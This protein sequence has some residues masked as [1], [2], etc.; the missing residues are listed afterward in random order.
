MFVARSVLVVA[1][2]AIA[3]GTAVAGATAAPGGGEPSPRPVDES[4]RAAHS[5][6]VAEVRERRRDPAERAQRQRSRTLFGGKSDREAIAVARAEHAG[7]MKLM[8]WKAPALRGEEHIAGWHDDYTAK[9]EGGPGEGAAL[10][11]STLPLRD[12]DREG[13][14]RLLDYSLLDV[15]SAF[16]P[17]NPLVDVRLPKQLTD[18]I[19]VGK[20]RVHPEGARNAAAVDVEDKAFWPNVD[21]DTDFVAV[22]TPVGVE[23]FHQLRSTDS[24]ET[25]RLRFDLPPGAV[26]RE[27]VERGPAGLGGTSKLFEV[28]RGDERLARI[29]PPAA[30]DADNMRVPM[31]ARVAGRTLV[32][33]VEHR[34]LDVRYPLMVDPFIDHFD[35]N[36]NWPYKNYMDNST[37]G[38]L[39][40]YFTNSGSTF[41]NWGWGL[42]GY[43]FAGTSSYNSYELGRWV[44]KA[45]GNAHI[46]RV[47]FGYV[48][49]Q[50]SGG[51]SNGAY[52][53]P[54]SYLE[55]G[56][57]ADGCGY[58]HWNWQT[59]TK[60]WYGLHYNTK[61]HCVNAQ[62]CDWGAGTSGNQAMFQ[63]V[64]P[65]HHYRPDQAVMML[66]TA[67]VWQWD[68][69]APWFH[70]GP[71]HHF[72]TSTWSTTGNFTTRVHGAD[73]GL[74]VEW[75]KVLYPGGERV[76]AAGCPDDRDRNS[77]PADWRGEQACPTR[78]NPD[79]GYSVGE[80]MH[81]IRAQVKDF[82]SNYATS[83][84]WNVRVDRS[85]PGLRLSGS[86]YDRRDDLLE[87]GT[88]NLTASGTDGDPAVAANRRSGVKRIDVLVDGMQVS[89]TG[90]RACTRFEASCPVDLPYTFNTE[91]W[92]GG[93]HDV[94]V[95]VTDHVNLTTEET[96]TVYT[97]EPRT[98]FDLNESD[99]EST[100]QAAIATGQ[101]R[102]GE[103]IDVLGNPLLPLS[104]TRQAQD[105]TG[106]T[107]NTNVVWGISDQKASPFGDDRL[108]SLN[109]G[110]A[111]LV[112]EFDVVA[113]ALGDPP[114]GANPDDYYNMD[115]RPPG[116]VTGSTPQQRRDD[117]DNQLLRVDRWMKKLCPLQNGTRQCTMQP[118]VA[119]NP[120]RK[121][122]TYDAGRPNPERQIPTVA[123]YE[124]AT[125]AFRQRYP[126]VRLYTGWN[127]AN[128]CSGMER[129]PERAAQLF[130]NLRAQCGSVC[131]VSAGDFVDVDNLTDS[132]RA[133]RYPLVGEEPK[134]PNQPCPTGKFQQG[135]HC[136]GETSA[137]PPRTYLQAYR[138]AVGAVRPAAWAVHAYFSGNRLRDD[139]MRAFVRMTQD[140]PAAP[141]N[142][143]GPNIW[144]TEQGGL[145]RLN[146]QTYEASENRE[147]DATK[148]T[149]ATR[150]V[151]FLVGNPDTN[152]QG[153]VNRFPR[154]TRFWL[155]NWRGG[156]DFDSGL[157]QRGQ[158]NGTPRV[159]A[160]RNEFWCYRLVTNPQTGDREKCTQ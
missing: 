155:Y 27:A 93:D 131:V 151:R 127:E 77:R 48:K 96:I 87:P 55:E 98:A 15:G 126:F 137:A 84:P 33:E 120:D 60:D 95:R 58:Y 97:D 159:T 134:D 109:L 106:S 158:P 75:A 28:V 118:L 149:R 128:C 78:F 61:T 103:P 39:G 6:K 4:S 76:A 117:P 34:D 138:D 83:G 5:A 125:R 160:A 69:V 41:N 20:L 100:H 82:S 62:T 91:E 140:D 105:G 67:H 115:R 130:L 12:V 150:A 17:G 132:S 148:G 122:N 66:G 108:Q 54:T 124:R 68:K 43:S 116:P 99:G 85:A 70:A 152:N 136:F 63:L 89:T 26:L 139:N 133:R 38:R 16:V 7:T 3:V 123:E 80:G 10:L 110:S 90:D 153:I 36:Q 143:A 92:P 81:E 29:L 51:S 42:Y 11:Q 1:A 32:L 50:P 73:D 79:I 13:R 65:D 154:I 71:Y 88:Y 24:P 14:S 47:E 146:N 119:F 18:G 129:D 37:D 141:V 52:Y 86:L 2:I 107:R 72:N 114:S 45:R 102:D 74:G 157:T 135:A 53:G 9:V 19:A 8:P 64:L 104:G 59:N 30:W 147:A 21:R 35:W 112:T 31:T 101:M 56:I 121:V 111:R 49:Y 25:L 94:T 144:L 113:E 145:Y 142:S 23:T 57:C 40:Y 44:F 156:F 46:P 22:P